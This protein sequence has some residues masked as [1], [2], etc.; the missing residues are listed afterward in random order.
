[1]V[2]VIMCALISEQSRESIIIIIFFFSGEN[3]FS[4]VEMD[5]VIYF[6]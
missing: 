4:S 6:K 1:M 5:G 3:G 2:Y